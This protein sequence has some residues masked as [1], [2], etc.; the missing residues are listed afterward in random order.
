MPYTDDRF[1]LHVEYECKGCEVPADER[2][3]MATLLEPLRDAVSDIPGTHLHITVIHHPRNDRYHVEFKLRLPGQT[4]PAD[5]EDRY[6]DTAFQRGLDGL[7]RSVEMKM[8]ENGR[9]GDPML[10]QRLAL[11]RA[12]LAPE[13]PRSGDLAR[14][15]LA[16]DYRAFRTA[17]AGYEEWLRKRVGRWIQRYPDAQARVGNG[18]RIGD[19]VEQVYLNAF[20]NLTR[21]PTDVRFSDW[22]VS[23]IDPSVKSLLRRPDEE[24]ENASLVRTLREMPAEPPDKR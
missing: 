14:T 7:L 4:V 3:R 2:A 18:L 16:G 1:D 24:R 6:L 22:L 19:V 8:R 23:L 10:S 15:V 21:R 5:A 12:M 11:D 20:E 9:V 17:L 13:D